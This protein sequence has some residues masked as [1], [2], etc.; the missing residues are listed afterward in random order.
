MQYTQ[1]NVGRVFVLRFD[2]GDDLLSELTAFVKKEDVRAGLLHFIGALESARIVVG[3][4]KVE[5]PPVPVWRDFADGREVLGLGTIF[6]KGDEPKIHIHGG[7]GRGDNINL[8]CIR[9]DAKVYL[10]I[11]AII[12]ELTGLSAKRQ[13]DEKTTLDL[14][15]FDD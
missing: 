5:V 14:L 4:E 3:P 8:G 1:C 10:T 12:L 6:W 13:A 11:E 15:E 2:H 7:I 9:K